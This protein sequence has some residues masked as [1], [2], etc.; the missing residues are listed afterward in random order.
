[1]AASTITRDSWVNDTGTA[2]APVGDGTLLANTVLQNHIY[3]RIDELFSGAGSYTTLTLGGLLVAEGFGTHS[4]SAGG[5]GGNIV[6]VRNTTAG[7]TNYAQFQLGIDGVVTDAGHVR[8]TTSTFT[9]TGVYQQDGLHVV[10]A[11]LGGVTIGSTNATANVYVYTNSTK[12]LTVWNNGGLTIGDGAAPG[13]GNLIVFGGEIKANAG[14]GFLLGSSFQT[15]YGG[16]EIRDQAAV[17]T[18]FWLDGTVAN[19]AKLYVGDNSNVNMTYGVTLNQLTADDEILAFKSSDVAHGMTSVAE[20]DTYGRVRKAAATTG[21]LLITGIGSGAIGF[22]HEGL[23]TTVDTTKAATS[24]AALRFT[25]YLKSGTGGGSLGANANLAAFYDNGNARAII[26]ADGDLSLDAVATNNVWDAHHDVALLAG[27]R[28]LMTGQARFARFVEYARPVLQQ[29]QVVRFNEDG[30]HFVSIKGL[31]GLMMDALRQEAIR[32]RA[33]ESV[34]SPLQR[35][36]F[37][38]RLA[39]ASE[40]TGV[41]MPMGPSA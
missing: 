3:A 11:R 13:A 20:T 12:R 29:T 36:R 38:E 21:G 2:S 9:A 34:L 28:G 27:V 19:A 7:T 23:V 35:R 24:G 15:A 39:T 40:E 32:Q 30:H 10:G 37:R 31:T 1:M 22:D 16:L 6:L 17:N 14:R 26:D 25:G 18:L 41:L 5:S 8:A 33:L 4:F